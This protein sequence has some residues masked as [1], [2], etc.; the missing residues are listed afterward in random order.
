MSFI[1]Q[2]F[3][4]VSKTIHSNLD[5]RLRRHNLI[6][7]NIVNADTPN[8]VPVDMD[9]RD[10]LE[11]VAQGRSGTEVPTPAVFYDPTQVPGPDGNAV[12]IDFEMTRLTLNQQTYQSSTVAL[13]KRLGL[14][15]YAIMEGR[16]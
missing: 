4:S 12:D 3:D 11:A 7:A 15:R 14:L 13:N 5:V 2:L 16:G 8:Y 1:N 10:T 6:S 9:F